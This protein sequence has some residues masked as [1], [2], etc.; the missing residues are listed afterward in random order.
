VVEKL[1]KQE[2]R[3][4]QYFGEFVEAVEQLAQDE[5]WDK[6]ELFSRRDFQ[7]MKDIEFV[8]EL[9]IIL[10]C[11]VLAE[12]RHLTSHGGLLFSK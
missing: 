7:R 9:F 8:S 4:S 5:F 1:N 11:C 3:H 2:L 10:D 6:A 12:S